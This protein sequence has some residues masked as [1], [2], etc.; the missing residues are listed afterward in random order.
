LVGHPA[1]LPTSGIPRGKNSLKTRENLGG[2]DSLDF[3]GNHQA[4]LPF[5]R[6]VLAYGR[7]LFQ[8][9]GAMAGC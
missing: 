3:V 1:R 4:I 8:K 7:L 2:L 6:A 5:L 9:V